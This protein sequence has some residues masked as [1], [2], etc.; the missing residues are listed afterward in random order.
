MLLLLYYILDA[1]GMSMSLC[2]LFLTGI[3]THDAYPR[4]PTSF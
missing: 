4:C 1:L 2:L 3:F